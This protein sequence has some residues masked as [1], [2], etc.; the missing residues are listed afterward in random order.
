[1][2][3]INSKMKMVIATLGLEVHWRGAVTVARLLRDY[4]VEVVFI[5][6][7]YPDEII[8]VAM[9]EGVDIVG[10]SSL[11]GGH[12]IL[13]AELL[14]TAR[15]K[16]IKDNVVFVIGGIFP[17]GDIPIL[18]EAG[19]DGMFGPDANG[20]E[21]YTFIKNAVSLKQKEHPDI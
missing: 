12:L 1:M 7:A 2:P 20:E 4:G 14:Q 19:F 6:N 21:I 16:G 15:Q 10:V 3:N 8:Q 5:G 13:G 9:Q 18:K 11:T 17:P